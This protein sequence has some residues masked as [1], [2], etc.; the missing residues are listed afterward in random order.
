MLSI[1]ASKHVISKQSHS[2]CTGLWSC[3]LGA[4]LWLCVLLAVPLLCV[5]GPSRQLELLPPP[6]IHR[7]AAVSKLVSSMD[8]PH[9]KRSVFL[10]TN[11]HAH[12]LLLRLL[13]RFGPWIIT[14]E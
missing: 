5:A 6:T 4:L 12:V 10:R 13:M 2:C 8:G 9:Q 11:T 14:A 3:L 7:L 1:R